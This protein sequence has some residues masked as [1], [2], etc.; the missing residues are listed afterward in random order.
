MP[1]GFSDLIKLARVRTRS[2]PRGKK[3]VFREEDSRIRNGRLAFPLVYVTYIKGQSAKVNESNI[4]FFLTSRFPYVLGR[5][6]DEFSEDVK[7]A[8]VIAGDYVRS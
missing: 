6:R 4:F 3:I 5:V 7:S 2:E 8:Y 1:A